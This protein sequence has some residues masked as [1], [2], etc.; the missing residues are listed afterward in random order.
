MWSGI[1]SRTMVSLSLQLAQ[2]NWITRADA[3]FL[4]V[5]GKTLCSFTV[6]SYHVDLEQSW[7]IEI[8][9]VDRRKMEY[10]ITKVGLMFTLYFNQ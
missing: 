4:R 6:V 5:D 1:N 9:E 2:W 3:G 8:R 7:L 10:L